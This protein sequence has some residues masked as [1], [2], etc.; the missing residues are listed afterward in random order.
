VHVARIGGR[1]AVGKFKPGKTSQI[2][3]APGDGI[4]PVCWYE[5]KGNPEDSSMWIEHKLI[6]KDLI[7]GHTLAVAD[8]DGDGNLDIYAAEM[9]KWSDKANA[10]DNPDAKAY[11]FYGN[12]KGNFKTTVFKKGMG[13]HESKVGD[14]DGDGDMDILAKPY[15]WQ[16]PRIDAFLQNGTGKL[17]PSILTLKNKYGLEMYSLRGE[18][19]KDVPAALKATKK[20]GINEV[21]VSGYY[22]LS[23][24]QFKVALQKEGLKCTSMLFDYDRYKNDMDGIIKEAKSFG[25]HYVGFAWIPHQGSFSKAD[26]INAVAFMNETAQKLKKSGLHFF[27]HPHGFEFIPAEGGGTLFDYIAQNT[28]P[29]M[30]FQL[31]A[32]WAMRGGAEPA[33]LLNKYPNRFSSL[34]IKDL[35]WGT[36]TSDYSGGAPDSTSV[37]IGK[38]QINWTEVLKAAIKSGVKHYYIED[39]A[40][41]AIEQ[42]PE[43]LRYL[44]NLK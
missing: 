30:S 44:K 41:N 33:L 16:A 17:L 12:G 10:D 24:S 39:E 1:V 9:A 5:C 42:I 3:T 4:G 21:E 15:T 6:D 31:D 2:V 35:M 18:L 22:G 40:E 7:H 43:S 38:G 11:I 20:M 37:V 13:F 36:P 32:F 19:K 27:Y 8:I 34:H 23:P 14:L 26:A 28:I 29:E 25:V